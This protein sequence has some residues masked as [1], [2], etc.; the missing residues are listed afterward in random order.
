MLIFRAIRIMSDITL[1]LKAIEL[2]EAGA[3]EDLLPLVY[4][5]LRRLAAA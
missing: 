2:G 4:V 1:M 5:E 3:L